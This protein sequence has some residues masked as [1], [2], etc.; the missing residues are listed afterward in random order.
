MRS[1]G[2]IFRAGDIVLAV[3]ILLCA[4]AVFVYYL[5]SDGAGDTVTVKSEAG[6]KSYP[7][8]RDSVFEVNSNGFTLSVEIKDGKVRVTDA[9]C[10]DKVC[11][12]T[13]TIASRGGSIA[14]VP[15]KVMISVGEGESGDENIDWVA[16]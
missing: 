15:A 5:H 13:G 8:D 16:P 6:V 12:H 9:D 14:C 7:L 10:P 1:E 11:V 4:A 2:R 3:I